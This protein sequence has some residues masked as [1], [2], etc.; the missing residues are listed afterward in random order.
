MANSVDPDQTLQNGSTLFALNTLLCN[1]LLIKLTRY[2]SAGNGLVQ[3]HKVEESIS[4]I[5]FMDTGLET[6]LM[7]LSRQSNYKRGLTG[8]SSSVL[9]KEILLK[10]GY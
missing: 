5:C 3:R 6:Y 8:I 7:A 10:Q 1:I 4:A 9:K 2:L